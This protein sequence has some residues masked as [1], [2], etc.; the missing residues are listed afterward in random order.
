MWNASASSCLQSISSSTPEVAATGVETRCFY[1]T[2]EAGADGLTKYASG[3]KKTAKEEATEE[4][5]EIKPRPS[6]AR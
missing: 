3:A 1:P 5:A 2:R 4:S 6:Y